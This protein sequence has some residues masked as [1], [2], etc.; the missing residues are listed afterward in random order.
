MNDVFETFQ[1]LLRSPEPNYSLFRRQLMAKQGAMSG[2]ELV[3]GNILMRLNLALDGFAEQRAG[4]SDG[5]RLLRQAI[6]A[7]EGRL[8]VKRSLWQVLSS[9]EQAFGLRATK[10]CEADMVELFADPWRPAWL[11]DVSEIDQLEQRRYDTPVIGDGLLYAMSDR[12]FATYQSKAQIA[13]GKECPFPPP[14]PP[15]PLP[16]PPVPVLYT[17]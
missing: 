16:F 12:K 17:C 3:R 14:G 9:R 5:S 1:E 8:E 15:L 4:T 2:K 11:A 6:R 7:Y 10:E 13:A